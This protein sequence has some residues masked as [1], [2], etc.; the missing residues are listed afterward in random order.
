[1]VID[2]NLYWMPEFLFSDSA[3]LKRFLTAVPNSKGAYAYEMEIPESGKKQ[4]VIEKPRGYQN[5]N[6]VEGQFDLDSQLSD[7]D[8]AG[9]DMAILKTPG[10][11]E[12]LDP[13]LCRIFND[14]MAEHVRKA[15]GRLRALAVLPPLAGDA[16]LKELD[17]CIGTLGMTGVQL[18]AHY[19]D[20]Y[21][22]D[23]SFRPV[24]S[25]LNEMNIPAY[26]H[27]TPLPVQ[28]DALL[29]YDNLR[30]SYGRSIDQV[31][32]IG[33]EIFSG[34]FEEFPRL[35]LVHS[36]L[37]GG[38]FTYMNLFF[39]EKSGKKEEL[40]RFQVKNDGHRTHF[41]NNI[42]FEMSHAMPWGKT[43][44]ETAIKVAGA[45]HIIFGSSYPV[46]REWLLDGPEFVRS[47]EIPEHD[48]SLV[49][50]GNAMRVYGIGEENNAG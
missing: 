40:G 16:C 21:L 6:Y 30:R 19:G 17:R 3:L 39:P 1:M 2:A 46:R 27:H 5:L 14:G 47:L 9:V 37:G 10:C 23:E 4:I 13:E 44:L 43:Q 35:R 31:I 18:S 20:R 50:S 24:L 8:A 15:R 12:W 26:I 29:D 45:D 7:M 36:M 41:K 32:A 49:L 48:R 38:F 22:D 33:R 11:Q 34:L 42:F 25:R 28:Y